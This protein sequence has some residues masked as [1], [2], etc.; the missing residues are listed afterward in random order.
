[1]SN[2]T[3]PAEATGTNPGPEPEPEREPIDWAA[4]AG[5]GYRRMLA[6]GWNPERP[7]VLPHRGSLPRL[8]PSELVNLPPPEYLIDGVLEQNSTAMLAG[9]PGHFK[10]FLAFDLA[11]RAATGLAWNGHRVNPVSDPDTEEPAGV[12]YIAGEGAN[13]LGK[14]LRAWQVHTGVTVPDD[15]L[16]IIPVPLNFYEPDTGFQ[17]LVDG[18]AP[19]P[20]PAPYGQSEEEWEAWRQRSADALAATGLLHGVRLSL[21]VVDTLA[22]NAT[23]ADE[24]SSRD[25]GKV[26]AAADELRR[27]T[28]ATVLLVHHTNKAGNGY[29]GSS[30]IGGFLTTHLE[31]ETGVLTCKKQRN[32]EPFAPMHFQLTGVPETG[33]AVLVQTAAPVADEKVTKASLVG[34][35]AEH[36]GTSLRMIREAL[37]GRN[38]AIGRLLGE[39]TAEGRLRVEPGPRNSKT[40]FL[41]Q[42]EQEGGESE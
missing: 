8:S 36:P 37:P 20:G 5:P 15:R 4:L 29:R 33:S 23:G 18:I 25:M 16:T 26:L 10:T 34:Y 31:L 32:G 41:G 21:I 1:M 35:V 22:V 11:C 38:A 40:Y 3:T 9:P 27:R 2:D 12:L 17:E 13:G 42:P 19:D 39:L 14:R 30:A 6:A 7:S 24:N 28:G